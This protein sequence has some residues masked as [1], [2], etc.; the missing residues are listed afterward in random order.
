VLLEIRHGQWRAGVWI[1]DETCWVVAAGLAKGGHKDRD[2]FYRRLER[3]ESSDGVRELLPSTQDLDLLKKERAHAVITEWQ[4]RNQERIIETLGSV[5]QGGTATLTI[6]SPLPN[7]PA[8]EAFAS[9][10][11]TVSISSEPD[12]CYEDVMVEVAIAD[13]WKTSTLAW[14]LIIQLLATISPPEQGWDVA[15]E[16]YSNLL[17]IG[18]LS[19][20]LGE[21]RDLQSRREIATTVAGRDAHYAH[22]RNLTEQTVEGRAARAL[23][24]VYFVPRRDAE[25]LEICPACSA[26]FAHIPGK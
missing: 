21:L 5:S 24:G 6:E 4:L 1:D 18:S 25:S 23:C 9:V 3:L 12:D 8:A 20:R 13:R 19:A 10:G 17:E 7:A 26:L 22:R 14:P 11:L 15:G 16:I 2:D